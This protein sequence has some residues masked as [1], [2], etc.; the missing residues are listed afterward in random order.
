MRFFVTVL[1]L[2]IYSFSFDYNLRAY[3]ITEGV[4]CFF[5]LNEKANMKNGGRVSNT[6]Y[7]ESKDGYIVID[8]GPTYSYAEQAYRI[9][10]KR[11]ALPIKYVINTSAH[12]TKILGNKFYKEQGATLIGP[13]SYEILLKEKRVPNL[14]TKI[15]K[16]AF[17][18]T[19]FM[20]LDIYQNS[21]SKISIGE[22]TL[23]IKK[24]EDGDSQHLVVFIPKRGIIFVGNYIY[25]SQKSKIE[26][27]YS[28]VELKKT[29]Y[30]IENLSWEYIISSRGTKMGRDTIEETRNHINSIKAPKRNIRKRNRRNRHRRDDNYKKR[31]VVQFA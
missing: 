11:E 15:S 31:V 13:K 7:V 3:T 20:P 17:I 10:Q 6:C 23:E 19:Q 25:N 27:H 1:L 21:H 2:T 12:E 14:S 16:D 30:K 24:F 26:N 29:I 8:S 18:N 9:M 28:L 22:I 4:S 5:G